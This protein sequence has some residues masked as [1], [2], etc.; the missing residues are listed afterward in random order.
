MLSAAMMYVSTIIGGYVWT[1]YAREV[2]MDV[3]FWNFSNSPNN[4]ASVADAMMFFMILHSTC[5]GTFSGGIDIIGVLL[6][7]FGPR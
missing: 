1:I 5:T 3:A 4:S 2:H 6:L 7:D